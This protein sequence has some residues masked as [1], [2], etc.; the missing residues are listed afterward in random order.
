MDSMAS[1]FWGFGLAA[2][3]VAILVAGVW[4]VDPN[5]LAAIVTALAGLGIVVVTQIFDRRRQIAEAHR[6]RKVKIYE[7]FAQLF[8]DLVEA[9]KRGETKAER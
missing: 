7:K 5:V 6:D 4:F 9:G 2:I 8:V 1:R 3:A